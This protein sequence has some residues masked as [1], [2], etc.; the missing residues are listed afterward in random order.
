MNYNPTAST[1]L[2]LNG[3]TVQA[4]VSAVGSGKPSRSRLINAVLHI[5]DAKHID[6]CD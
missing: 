2:S 6:L 3:Q 4:I 5:L 1:V